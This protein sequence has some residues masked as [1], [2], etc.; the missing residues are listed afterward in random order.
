M[1]ENLL[2]VEERLKISSIPDNGQIIL[3]IAANS[4]ESMGGFSEEANAQFT[5]IIRD[6]AGNQTIGSSD[7]TIIHIDEITPQLDSVSISSNNILSSNWAN[8]SD[9]ITISFT[10]EEG[11]DSPNSIILQD[12]INTQGIVGG[13]IWNG[14]YIIQQEDL[15]G[16]VS[17]NIHYSDTAGNIGV[18]VNETTD[19]TNVSIDKTRPDI[20]N[21]LEGNDQ[22]DLPYYNNA[23]SVT[24]Y[25]IHDDTV[26]GIRETYYALGTDS[27]STDIIGWTQGQEINY[28]GWNN[29]NLSN[30]GIYFGGAFVRDSAG[31]F[32]D[33]I[34]GNGIYIDIEKP[35]TGSII[36][37]YWI[38][39]LDY[40]PDSTQLNYRLSNFTDNTEIDHFKI[41]IGT[42]NDT[43]D[44]LDWTIS[45]T[46]DSI[47]ITGL[48]LIRDTLYNT[49]IKAVDLAQNESA[50]QNTDGIYFDDSFPV[51]NRIDPDFYADTSQ[52]LSVLSNDTIQLKFNRPIYSYDV[53]ASSN[54]DS[55]FSY[56]H[57]Y[58]DSV[59]SIIIDNI[60][61][62]YDTITLVLDSVTAYNTLTLT[63]TIQF[64]SSLWADL[65]N[66]YDITVEDI[67]LF[68]QNWPETD[69]GPFSDHP[70]HVRPQPDGESNLLDL[71]AF[72]KMWQW[73]YFNLS[74]DTAN[75]ARIGGQLDIVGR[76]SK[77]L[78]NIPKNT[79][80]AE[81]LIGYSNVDIERMNL[82]KPKNTT[83]LFKSLDTL[84]Q[85][86]QFSLAD[87]RGLD[88]V[89]TLQV[90]ESES[91]L[92]SSTIQ[93]LFL[94]QEGNQINK[95]I[96]NFNINMLPDKFTVYN[97]YPN[98][99]NPITT[100][101]YDL[102]EVRDVQIRIIDLVGRT[103]TSSEI[104]GH[105]PGR[106]TYTWNGIN[107]LGK[108]VST[109]MY[110]FILRAGQ[111]TN[112]QKMLLLK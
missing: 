91:H 61:S 55:I 97:N 73:R 37:G 43:T 36:D 49:Y 20:S 40:T 112:I 11:L 71:S 50:I 105:K 18:L 19:G 88:S 7:N 44:V 54:V 27:N 12:T 77:V 72:A 46:T 95:G 47:T 74:F 6:R 108:K 23:D 109:G 52:F 29:L 9:I 78:F 79:S 38:M 85:M 4:F 1:M 35:D 48:S 3:G 84:G 70:P 8:I 62:S 82:I 104:I 64:F 80:M 110:F 100:I 98:P 56:T 34:W 25:W 58:D 65:N 28:G 21:L 92:F 99:F 51:V 60:L 32:S 96:S 67:L 10:S 15:E 31:N 66:D 81:I 2:I 102:P 39:D 16:L 107:N 68:N 22:Q 59:I 76:G 87:H 13:T 24:L 83:F 93:Y 90:P 33:T 103:I 89:L 41:A 94:D 14:T 75:V 111:D 26:S 101:K 63:D 53:Q 86:V 69:L 17:F 42:G 57:E 30:D 5:T 106:H 45:D